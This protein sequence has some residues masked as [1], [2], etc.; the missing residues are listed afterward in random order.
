MLAQISQRSSFAPWRATGWWKTW[1]SARNPC[2][3]HKLL[4][5]LSQPLLE[6]HINRHWRADCRC[7]ELRLK[8]WPAPRQSGE[9]LCALGLAWGFV[10]V[11]DGLLAGLVVPVQRFAA[12]GDPP[13]LGADIQNK[14]NLVEAPH[15]FHV[16]RCVVY[17]RHQIAYPHLAT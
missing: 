15:S 13:A 11:T 17:P 2:I 6:N 5:G 8:S 1:A 10:R 12:T 16:P 9:A 3:R 4:Q 14:Q 7:G